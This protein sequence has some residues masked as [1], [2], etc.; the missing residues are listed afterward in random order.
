MLGDTSQIP[1]H[2][3]RV[4]TRIRCPVLQ[5]V[6]PETKAVLGANQRGEVWI[7]GPNVM[8]GY[9]NKPQATRETI[10]ENG[11]LHTGLWVF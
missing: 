10:D 3:S 1:R 9:L 6:D 8:K 4:L 5:I 7:R 2:D 11:W